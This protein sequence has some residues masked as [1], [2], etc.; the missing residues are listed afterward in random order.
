MR[1]LPP[2]PLEVVARLN[3]WQS[4]GMTHPFTCPGKEG[5]PKRELTATEEGWTCACGDYRQEWAHASMAEQEPP[6]RED[7]F[8]G[9]AL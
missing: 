7:V 2:W 8:G 4:A 5:C 3:R 9:S 6:S 1:S